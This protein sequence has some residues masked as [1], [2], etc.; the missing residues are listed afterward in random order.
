M[1]FLFQVSNGEMLSCDKGGRDPIFDVA[2]TKKDGEYHFWTAGKKHIAYWENHGGMIKKKRGIFG[3]AGPQT[4]FVC[5]TADDTGKG[6]GGG[7]NSYIYI[8]NGNTCMKTLGYH[9]GGFVGAIIWKE[10]T[11]YSGGKDG[12][13]CIIDCAANY[14]CKSVVQF[15]TLIRAIDVMGT[16]LVVGLRTGSIVESDLES[17]EQTTLMQGH[18]DGE[19]WGLSMDDA[20]VYTSGDDNQVKQWDPVERKCVQTAI[21]SD[22]SRKAQR[23][24]AS[25]MGKHPA[26]QAA[27]ALAV[28]CKGHLAV[29]SNDGAM[30]IRDLSDISHDKALHHKLDSKEWIEVAEYSPDGAYLAV[31]SHDTNIYIYET[32]GYTKTGT[33]SKHNATVTCIDWSMDGS[34]IKSVCNGYELLYFMMPGGDQDP[35]G[36]SNTTSTAW[37]TGHA[38]FGWLVDGIYPKGTDGSHI[39]GVDFSED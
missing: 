37:A 4:S 33:A 19:V 11:L 9:E 8:W 32:E 39:N 27:R 15:P 36:R 22:K 29:C 23:N 17:G 14:E 31:G 38:K 30:T 26:S 6:F 1:V 12:R 10:G 28:S 13:V 21:V 18:N 2:F 34:Y 3:K 25:S 35:S 5:M 16:K 20:H 24:K 7:A